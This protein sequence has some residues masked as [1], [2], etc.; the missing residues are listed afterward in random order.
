MVGAWVVLVIGIAL[1]HHFDMATAQKALSQGWIIFLNDHVTI[2]LALSILSAW[3]KGYAAA[4]IQSWVRTSSRYL[5][6]ITC[7]WNS[8]VFL[9]NRWYKGILPTR[10]GG[11]RESITKKEKRQIPSKIAQP[12]LTLIPFLSGKKT[13]IFHML[14]HQRFAVV[15]LGKTHF[16]QFQSLAIGIQGQHQYFKTFIWRKN[17]NMMVVSIYSTESFM[18]KHLRESSL[19]RADN[20]LR[21][22][23]SSVKMSSVL[24]TFFFYSLI[25]SFELLL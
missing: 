2:N 3:D 22:S 9:D 19:K 11:E 18:I 12:S 7:L 4:G 24:S 21:L 16:V 6:H 13:F 20:I 17:I 10:R 8:M 14:S 5:W 1:T 23:C 15:S 25:F